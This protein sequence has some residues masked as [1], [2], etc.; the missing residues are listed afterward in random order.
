MSNT[1]QGIESFR[2]SSTQTYE[3]PMPSLS[4]ILSR[5]CRLRCLK[6]LETI[7][8]STW[9]PSVGSWVMERWKPKNVHSHASSKHLLFLYSV[10]DPDEVYRHTVS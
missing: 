9:A 8:Y 3:S 5:E 10:A 4:G 6:E 7:K 1:D 2:P